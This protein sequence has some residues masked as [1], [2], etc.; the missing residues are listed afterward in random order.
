MELKFILEAILFSAQKA[1]N[2]KELRDL[3]AAAAEHGDEA[4]P[5]KK[6]KENDIVAALEQLQKNHEAAGRSYRLACV[7][8][9]WQFVSQAQYAPWIM[10][11]VG[12]KSRPPRL[13]QPALETLAIIAYRQPITR[14][15]IEQVRGV[16]VDGVM[17]T[18]LERGLVEQLGR[19][20]VV[21]RP[22]TYGT[23]VLFLEYFGLRNLDEL[24]AAD[25]L[26]RIPVTRPEAL[27]TA[28]PGLATVAPEQVALAE[29][30]SLTRPSAV[31]SET[32]EP[33]QAQTGNEHTGP[34]QSDR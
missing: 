28:E 21:G 3:L 11:L 20:E 6:T 12:T 26:R 23:T 9:G 13:S 5:F 10:A 33:N 16:A 34:S 7:A 30:E 29:V 15:E 31:Q 18:L 1:L 19:A 14:A 8:G 17:Q 4:K 22:M 24:P 32:E 2:P 27:L 25:E